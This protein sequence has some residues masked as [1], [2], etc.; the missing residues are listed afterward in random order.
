[1][2]CLVLATLTIISLFSKGKEVAKLFKFH[3]T[4]RVI[5]NYNSRS[6]PTH[7]PTLL[8]IALSILKTTSKKYFFGYFLWDV[9]GSIKV[10][11]QIGTS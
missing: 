3:F 2:A 9:R 4:M 1:M 11:V 6:L 5:S 7:H 10:E 8:I